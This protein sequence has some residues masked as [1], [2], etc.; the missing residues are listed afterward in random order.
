MNVKLHLMHNN[1]PSCYSSDALWQTA[2]ITK[3]NS[4]SECWNLCAFS[5]SPQHLTTL[6][7][8]SVLSLVII[9]FQSQCEWCV[10]AC[11]PLHYS[12]YLRCVVLAEADAIGL[13]TER[14][15]TWYSCSHWCQAALN[16][17]QIWHTT[18]LVVF[19]FYK[20]KQHWPFSA[21]L[22]RTVT[23]AVTR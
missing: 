15:Q 4:H 7:P 19:L 21:I 12:R 9:P 8:S 13:E 2:N 14:H 3:G 11:C 5:G 17:C 16:V 18:W 22:F 23:A 20:V 10:A 6:W 1:C